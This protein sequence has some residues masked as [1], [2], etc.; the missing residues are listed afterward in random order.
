MTSGDRGQGSQPAK[1]ILLP[2]TFILL[3]AILALLLSAGIWMI[4]S[5][6]N[7]APLNRTPAPLSPRET[8]AIIGPASA[9]QTPRPAIA[10]PAGTAS[11]LFE[12]QWPA[13]MQQDR[14]DTV[15]LTLRFSGG[16]P[17]PGTA[18]VPGHT[19][20]IATPVPIGT[21]GVPLPK[22]LGTDYDLVVAARLDAPGFLVEPSGEQAYRVFPEHDVTWVWAVLPQ[23]YGNQVLSLNAV[24]RWEPRA[25]TP[26][27]TVQYPI[28]QQRLPTYVAVPPVAF[29]D[30]INAAT[31]L[32][33]LIGAALGWLGARV[34]SPRLET[35]L[36]KRTAE[37]KQSKSP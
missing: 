11:E 23:G 27:Q 9:G 5:S 14:S 30:P 6:G 20:S 2:V 25:G 3:A 17:A 37:Q 15:Q 12:A 13:V 4:L 29:P 28:Y 32:A 18:Q 26:G 33:S 21:P 8:P 16:Q 36:D 24:A 31:I 10:T 19:A 35:W 7:R 1:R 34:L 22:W